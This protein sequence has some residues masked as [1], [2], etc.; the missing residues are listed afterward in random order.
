MNTTYHWRTFTRRVPVR[1]S[2]QAIYEAWTTQHGL[3]R[4]FLRLSVFTRPSGSLRATDEQVQEGD[5][6]R[7]LWFGYDD[8]VAEAHTILAANGSDRLQ[9]SFSGGCIVTVT[10]REEQGETI[11]ELVQ[12]MPMDDEA[13]QRFYYIE[14]GNGW[15]FYLANLKSVLEEGIDLRN[16]N[17]RLQKVVNA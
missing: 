7:W 6:Y 11:C 9:F 8:C 5:H 12:E 16:K 17:G 15:T 2:I 3:E 13:K 4:W 14:C 10:I 1:A